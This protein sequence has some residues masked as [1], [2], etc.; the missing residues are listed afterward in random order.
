MLSYQY[1][2]V[3]D[4]NEFLAPDAKIDSPIPLQV[5]DRVDIYHHPDFHGTYEVVLIKHRFR[6]EAE[7]KTATLKMKE[8]TRY[9]ATTI[10]V[11]RWV[12]PNGY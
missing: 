7:S 2:V 4:E 8:Q 11:K 3:E 10:V 1:H 6:H 12:K 9:E 5:G